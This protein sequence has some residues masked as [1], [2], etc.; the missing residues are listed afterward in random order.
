MLACVVLSACLSHCYVTVSLP[1]P[2]VFGE[3]SCHVHQ[4]PFVV[5]R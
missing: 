2:V 5:T 3:L 4:C 1:D